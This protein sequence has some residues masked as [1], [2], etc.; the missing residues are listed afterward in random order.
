MKL[1]VAHEMIRSVIN[2]EGLEP[3][4]KMQFENGKIYL[5]AGS[6]IA[7][8]KI[9]AESPFVETAGDFMG[10]SKLEINSK[11]EMQVLGGTVKT[12]LGPSEA[13]LRAGDG[14]MTI[15]GPFNYLKDI[16]KDKD[17]P[18]TLTFSG[19]I[20]DQNAPVKS[21]SSLTY[22]A[23]TI[24]LSA[25]TNVL[26]SNITF[27][28]PVIIDGDNVKITSGLS[29]GDIKF[30]STLDADHPSRNLTIS[31]GS[32]S[33]TVTFKEPI[34]SKGPFSQLTVET[35]KAIFSNI[36]DRNR[37]GADK[38][39]V[40]SPNVEFIGSVAH[41][42]E[43]TWAAPNLYVKSGQQTTFISREKPLIFSSI[44]HISLSPQTNIFFETHGGGFEFA[45]LSGDNQQA[46]SVNTRDGG[47]SKIG[48]LSGKLGPLR[49]QSRNIYMTGK[50]D[51]GPIFMEAH[52]NIG[53]AAHS[54]NDYRPELLSE[55]EV[56]LNAKHGMVGTKEF[57]I[58][59]KSKGKLYLGA[60]SYAHVEG[61]FA[62]GFP[63]VYK[64]NP[65]PRIVYQGN[66]TQY[67]FNEEIFMEEEEIMSLTPDLYHIIP[68]GFVDPTHF[69]FRRAAIYFTRGDTKI[70]DSTDEASGAELVQAEE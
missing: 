52:E 54:L 14:A 5:V 34:G 59:V 40:K 53:Y 11:K 18:K 31:N 57:P 1:R 56:T 38:L 20:I 47:D 43:Q 45:K 4:T 65:P 2:V 55:G 69:S 70:G 66:E 30:N 22:A 44:T 7:A 16:I 25:D 26:N 64:N 23:D 42:K 61:Y 58:L 67:V 28:G 32:Q 19:K 10:V 13:S 60:K 46:V 8:P 15:D 35:G 39:I 29:F 33:G 49:V 68:Y 17:A 62:H 24:L 36:G 12:A 6:S 51:V 3:A 9:K 63:Y 37:P 48:E 21:K 41:A 50:V 27:N